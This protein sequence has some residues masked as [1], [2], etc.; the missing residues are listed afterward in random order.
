MVL[1]AGIETGR[2]SLR[3]EGAAPAARVT[4]ELQ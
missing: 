1:G 2:V 3:Q 4:L